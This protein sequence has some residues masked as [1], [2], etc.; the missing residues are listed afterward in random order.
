M[1]VGSPGFVGNR[2]REAREARQMTAATLAE[3]I[4]VT[5]AGISVYERGHNTPSPDVLNRIA[6]ALRFKTAFF[7]RPGGYRNSDHLRAIP[8]VGNQSDT[9]TRPA[10]SDLVAGDLGVP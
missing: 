10:S 1:P 8:V 5:P 2:L 7:F 4:G 6:K 3:L 9:A